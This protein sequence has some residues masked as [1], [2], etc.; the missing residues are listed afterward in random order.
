MKFKKLAA[1][2]LTGVLVT[3]M[4]ASAFAAES[5]S[6]L[7]AVGRRSDGVLVYSQ[8]TVYLD[9][10]ESDIL[11]EKIKELGGEMVGS[12][13]LML[14]EGDPDRD[15][16][17]LGEP[18]T[19]LIASPYSVTFTGY[20]P[21]LRPQF[22]PTHTYKVLCYDRT[23][24]SVADAAVV[25]PDDYE[26]QDFFHRYVNREET[27]YKCKENSGLTFETSELCSIFI[28]DLDAETEEPEAKPGDL[29]GDGQLTVSDMAL[30]ARY[31]VGDS[32]VSDNVDKT[33]AD[34]NGDGEVNIMDLVYLYKLVAGWQP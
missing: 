5:I 3:V 22:D 25:M 29:S 21:D 34:V 23:S 8:S 33:I 12:L 20:P 24:W 28:I 7:G 19:V 15:R 27:Y 4:S 16:G 1:L 6:P 26:P 10:K 2:L 17:T 13:M 30:L 9:Q 18:V 32:A 11:Q 14:R 31:I